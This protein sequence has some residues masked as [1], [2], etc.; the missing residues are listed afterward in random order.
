MNFTIFSENYYLLKHPD[1]KAAVD[2]KIFNSGLEHFKI[3]GLAEGRVNISPYYFEQFYLQKYSDVAQAVNSGFFKTGVEHFL[4]YGFDE[5]RSPISSELEQLYLQKHP[6]VAQAVASGLI[7]SAYNHFFNYGFIEGRS[8]T[9]F[10]EQYYSAAYPD[11][12]QAV[13]DR[14][15]QSGFDHFWQ[16][17]QTEERN[18]L[19]SGTSGDDIIG[20]FGEYAFLTGVAVNIVNDPIPSANIISNG[21]DEQDILIS[22]AQYNLFILGVGP[23]QNNPNTQYFYVG[24]NDTD[25]ALIRQFYP[26]R[27]QIQLAGTIADYTL[28]P[29]NGNL[30]IYKTTTV[31]ISGFVRSIYDLVAVVEGVTSLQVIGSD[32][33]NNI[34]FLG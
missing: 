34:V 14:Y 11:V 2:A 31:A 4:N 28:S 1:V 24:G 15:F 17:G 29:A 22:G 12:A 30:N 21:I 8:P 20:S 25:Y 9:F 10:N 16:F 32:P 6:D 27:D 33:S 18:A 3:A 19:F 23:D 13:K 5:G 7:P 26:E